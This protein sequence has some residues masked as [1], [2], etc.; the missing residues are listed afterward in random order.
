MKPVRNRR[1]GERGAMII[2]AAVASIAFLALVALAVD[3][4][5]KLIA[6]GQ[7]Q[8]SA[9][10]GALA[11]AISLAFDNTTDLTDTGLPKR[12]ARSY[13]LENLV[14]GEQPDV[15]ITN[16][17]KFIECP[18]PDGGPGTTCVQVDVYRNQERAN[19]LPTFFSRLVGVTDQ[20]VKATA[21]AKVLSASVTDCL[22]PWVVIDRW[23]EFGPTQ[24][25]AAD[26]EWCEGNG[27]PC[28][29]PSTYDK[30]SD[31]PK[32]GRPVPEPDLYVP[33]APDG[34]SPGTGFRA[35]GTPN[36]IGKRFALKVQSND[37][38]SP[39]WG[40]AVDLPRAD[41]TNM[42]A[43]AYGSNI[44]SCSR[45]PVGIND[46]AVHT[47]PNEIIGY[48]DAVAEAEYGCVRVQTGTMQGPTSI[49]VGDLIDLDFNA[50]WDI[51]PQGTYGVVDSCCS[52]SPRIVPVAIMDVDTY[53]S[54]NP[55]GS[56][57]VVRIVNIFGF[58][59]E[60]MGDYD[61]DTGDITLKPGGKAVV[62]R[63]MKFSGFSAGSTKLHET[64]SWSKIIVLVR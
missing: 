50:K 40:L 28:G 25:P 46:P 10:A 7:A 32:G 60:G 21:T 26:P 56:G 39:G 53:L 8:R 20:G 5:V 16:D 52:E 24:W 35:S 64:A 1:R 47:C 59:I 45:V 51:T 44:T 22:R 18:N 38:I 30:Y 23:D 3:Y 37:A 9:D 2:Q 13:A 34:S 48:D 61:E 31:G 58:F 4:G 27:A 54:Q 63:L 49:N 17:I 19:A 55:T 14:F 33:P 36:D 29:V 57:G 6:R 41:T 12:S 15:N 11:G 43:E 42:G 62:G